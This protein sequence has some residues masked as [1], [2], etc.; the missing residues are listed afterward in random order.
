MTKRDELEETY[1]QS[2]SGEAFFS[3]NLVTGD[4]EF[5][6]ELIDVGWEFSD[7]DSIGKSALRFSSWL[8]LMYL[9][10]L[11]VVKGTFYFSDDLDQISRIAGG[12]YV[13]QVTND[14]GIVYA[15][16]SFYKPGST[17]DLLG[18]V[19]LFL[20]MVSMS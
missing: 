1:T 15:L 2:T 13:D 5:R 20:I 14:G 8:L 11:P 17:S 18:E 19:S 6:F 10:H 12:Y 3:T 7:G 16:I 4:P 9:M